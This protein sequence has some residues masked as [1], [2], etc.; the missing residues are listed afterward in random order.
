MFMWLKNGYYLLTVYSICLVSCNYD[1]PLTS[2][3]T[4]KTNN[5]HELKGR[6]VSPKLLITPK[7][8]TDIEVSVL[9][10]V[11]TSKGNLNFKTSVIKEK[12]ETIDAKNI[13]KELPENFKINR[14][15]IAATCTVSE[16]KSPKKVNVSS[17]KSKEANPQNFS[18]YS[19]YEGLSHSY[20]QSVVQGPKG[21]LWIATYGG[22]FCKYNGK[23]FSQ[24][25]IKQGLNS[26]YIYTISVDK[27][28]NIWYN[29]DRNGISK[30]DGKS[31]F[32]FD[33]SNGLIHNKVNKIIQDKN[34]DTWIATRE[35]ISILNDKT[36]HNI[37]FS[38]KETPAFNILYVLCDKANNKW[39]SIKDVGILK[40]EKNSYKLF[41]P[42]N[43]NYFK[44][45]RSIM[46]DKSG[47]IWFACFGQGV[48]SL[49]N[50]KIQ[51]INAEQ[52]LVS[53]ELNDVYEDSENNIWISTSAG[54]SRISDNII[55]NFGL[56]DGLSS[57]D[58]KSVFEDRSGNIWISTFAGLNL[59]KGDLFN[60]FTEK[61]GISG[62]IISSI[63]KDSQ[64]KLWLCTNNG[65]T[66]IND[67]EITNFK[68]PYFYKDGAASKIIET[69]TGALIFVGKDCV[70]KYQ[71]NVFTK[72]YSKSFGEISSLIEDKFGNFWV[73]TYGQ[74]L[75]YFNW[76]EILL[77]DK[78]TGME[79]DIIYGF[80]QDRQ[81]AIW[82]GTYYGL[83]KIEYQSDNY[84]NI[85][86]TQFTKKEGLPNNVIFSLIEDS[87]GKLWL[88]TN[89]SGILCIVG[90]QYIKIDENC[91]LSNSSVYAIFQ[92]KNYNIWV[93]TR[94]GINK[95]NTE[96]VNS[97]N[98]ESQHDTIESD[99]ITYNYDDG[100]LGVNCWRNSIS[101]DKNGNVWFGAG[102]RLTCFHGIKEK[103]DTNLPSVEITNVDLYNQP[104]QWAV[105]EKNKD[106]VLQLSNG[107]KIKNFDFDST[108]NWHQLPQNLKLD[109]DNN[110]LNFNFIGVSTKR[111]NKNKY[112][113]I[114][115]GLDKHWSIPSSKNSAEYGNLPAGNYLF[116]VKFCNNENKWSNEKTFAFSIRPPWF[117]TYFAYSVY[118]IIIII[119]ITSY[120]KFRTRSLLIKQKELEK[121]VKDRTF[122]VVR[123][124]EIAEQ[125]KI[126]VELKNQ[127]IL[128]SLHYAQK[129]QEAILPPFKILNTY[130]KEFFIL[131][132]PKDIVA[133]DFYWFEAISKDVVLI[134]A[135][136]CTGH[137]VPGAMISVVCSNAL[138]RAVKEF[139]LSTPNLILNKVRALVLETFE[140]S[141]REVYDGMDISLCSL[142]I[143]TRKVAWAGA[144]IPFW[145]KRKDENIIEEV[146]GDK[147]S[148][149]LNIVVND[150]NNH[151]IQL[152]E[153][154]SFYLFTDGFVDQF[155]GEK[156]GKF[157]R[158]RFKE[159]LLK[160]ANLP[161]KIQ[162]SELEKTL[163]QWQG[164]LEQVD[165]ICVIGIRV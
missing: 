40:F 150:F 101:E 105:I 27:K 69:K 10:N 74:G 136:D 66:S 108:S 140:K 89:G 55:K 80:I 135:A 141:E 73:G 163:H 88:G 119:A 94:N 15:D 53:N 37:T 157:L 116:K 86:I 107:L 18:S 133:G 38:N 48:A 17:P 132:K 22:G 111:A 112:Q 12:I 59:Y 85:K 41:N 99:I 122:E 127:E 43:N 68:M 161:M 92:D 14:I 32:H 62:N 46:Q 125:Q 118:L 147:Q 8:F 83:Y 98:S 164:I 109:Y 11:E 104:I 58:C 113:Y 103:K 5:V 91:G 96:I 100:F 95:L 54:L 155:G 97:I 143:K 160:N 1:K 139:H 4:V 153:G 33:E 162:H 13:W 158:K 152:N 34:D 142:N 71:N 90:N 121:I 77:Y 156:G 29:E 7:V 31:I 129:L 130:L 6:V 64:N 2:K 20:V 50:D 16:M 36:F 45:V 61:E 24:Y 148:I 123:Q 78:N 42:K 146:K 51:Y 93:G 21:N 65:I 144:N 84:R 102:D 75:K 151:T 82:L 126:L 154:D 110:F 114:L 30:F 56:S 81:G 120:I 149:A 72:Y 138:N 28:S 60:H 47:R 52:G 39:I 159:I 134:A 137:G 87:N 145:I 35:G 70:I 49:K 76:K 79:S 165:D 3:N 115:E 63:F 9:T 131:Y 26:D 23:Y 19:I 124:K 57:V 106:T 44:D 117:R 25:S 67:N 128:D